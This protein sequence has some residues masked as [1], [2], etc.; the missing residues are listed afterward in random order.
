MVHLEDAPMKCQKHSVVE[1]SQPNQAQK[2]PT[3]EERKKG[4][5]IGCPHVHQVEDAVYHNWFSPFLWTQILA[6]GV[7]VGWEMSASAII[8]C[9]Q[10]KDPTIFA[11]IS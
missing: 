7:E 1:L 10:K 4:Q 2:E 6:A 8:N 11:K 9:F 3:H 5:K